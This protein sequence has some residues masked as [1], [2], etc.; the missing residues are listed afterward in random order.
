MIQIASFQQ[1]Y[2]TEHFFGL[3]IGT[4]G[5]IDRAIPGSQRH[6]ILRGLQRFATDEVPA[7]P[8]FII[9]GETFLHHSLTFRLGQCRVFGFLDE[10]HANKLHSL[11]SR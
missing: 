2:P 10:S 6:S 1:Q 3:N 5:D 9:V 7:T 8:Q 11:V 4:I